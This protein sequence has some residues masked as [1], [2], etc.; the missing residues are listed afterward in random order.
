MLLVLASL[1]KFDDFYTTERL[2]KSHSGVIIQMRFESFL[3]HIIQ[4]ESF[5]NHI[6]DIVCLKTSDGF[7]CYAAILETQQRFSFFPS[8]KTRLKTK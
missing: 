5:K 8:C 1:A 7:L 3:F 2:A 6:N 4:A